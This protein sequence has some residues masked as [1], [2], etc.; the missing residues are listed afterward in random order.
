MPPKPRGRPPKERSMAEIEDIIMREGLK[1]ARKVDRERRRLEAAIAAEL[2]TRRAHVSETVELPVAKPRAE[3]RSDAKLREAVS[4]ARSSRFGHPVETAERLAFFKAPAILPALTSLADQ[5]NQPEAGDAIM[6]ATFR[7]AVADRV[8]KSK[9]DVRLHPKRPISETLAALRSAELTGKADKKAGK[10]VGGVN[11]EVVDHS[12]GRLT[13]KVGDSH[14]MY[15]TVKR[16]S[17]FPNLY[18][19]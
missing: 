15:E 16:I 9:E 8:R 3:S 17:L 14:D 13:T 10:F 18:N 5:I 1:E 6:E 7:S 11:R 12:P 4:A 2:A 19:M